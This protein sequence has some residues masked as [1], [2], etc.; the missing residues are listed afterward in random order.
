MT[1]D[2]SKIISEEEFD[3]MQSMEYRLTKIITPE[4]VLAS[5]DDAIF[6]QDINPEHPGPLDKFTKDQKV[7]ACIVHTCTGSLSRTGSITQINPS[8]IANWRNKSWWAVVSN[9]IQKI[10]NDVLEAKLTEIIE[11]ATDQMLDRIRNG[12]EVYNHLNGE[13]KRI[14]V[15][16]KDLAD[17]GLKTALEKRSEIRNTEG[18]GN[19]RKDVLSHLKKLGEAFETIAL[20]IKRDE[21]TI[22]AEIISKENSNGESEEGN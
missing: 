12:D 15:K 6:Y 3:R 20:E 18:G 7:Y 2:I 16:F 21:R 9:Q 17:S 8:T 5:I 10:R 14:P 1:S 13:V 4:M 22:E 11:E 19:T